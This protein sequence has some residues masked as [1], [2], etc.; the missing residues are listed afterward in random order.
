MAPHGGD[1]VPASAILGFLN[2]VRGATAVIAAIVLPLLAG[3]AA[4]AIDVGVWTMNKR[5]AQGA[6]DQ[7]AYTAL[8]A[9]KAG[10]NASQATVDAKA[11]AANMG[12]VDGVGGTTV[13]VNNPPST[14]AYSGNSGY[15]EVLVGQPQTGW[16]SNYFLSSSVTARARAVVGSTAGGN[17]CVVGLSTT[18]APA[19]DF[20][21]GSSLTNS[22]CAL[23]VNSSN[24]GALN[25]A[26]NATIAASTYVVGGVTTQPNC[27]MTGATNSTGVSATPNPY[28]SVS[29]TAPACTSN[30]AVTAGGTYNPG[31]YC[32]GFNTSNNSTVNL[33][34]GVYYIDRQFRLGNN[35]TLNASGGV[36]LIFRPD[37]S[38]AT[39]TLAFGN[40][41]ILRITAPTS[42]DFQGM[43]M[44]SLT[45]VPANPVIPNNIVMQIHGALY[46]PSSLLTVNNNVGSTYCTQ[47]VAD[48]VL[49]S[50]NV[51]ISMNANCVGTGVRSFGNSTIA[52][53]E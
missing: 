1:R 50:N 42:G 45:N 44:V 25:C 15:W 11:I 29:V 41:S 2:D 8:V 51:T 34:P 39:F 13:T 14:G 32:Q 26:N 18:A 9:T 19:I 20:T 31:R 43:A 47:I 36:T 17:A 3:M 6:A 16:F 30:T 23:Y 53:V 35:A 40:N 28:A 52:L 5:Q 33:N 37:T 27:N 4:I 21:N 38:I 48:R 46:F 24:A 10:A 12:F 49:F 22:A 7:A